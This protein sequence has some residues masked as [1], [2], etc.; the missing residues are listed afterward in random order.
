MDRK[1]IEKIINE[2]DN[3]SQKNCDDDFNLAMY[4]YVRYGLHHFKYYIN[5]DELIEINKVLK[6]HSTLF[7]EDLNDDI[8]L[9]LNDD[10][11][12]EED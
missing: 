5:D 9:I 12:D 10:E 1:R 2:I 11:D 4:L 7:D 3:I 6:R 8:R